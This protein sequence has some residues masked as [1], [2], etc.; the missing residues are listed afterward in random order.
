[1]M[2]FTQ[3]NGFTQKCN[4][5]LNALRTRYPNDEFRVLTDDYDD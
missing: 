1:M 3:S 2:T 5:I 4:D